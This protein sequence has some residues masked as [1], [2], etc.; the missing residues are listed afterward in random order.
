MNSAIRI[1]S[2][3]K[4]LRTI[5]DRGLIPGLHSHT[6]SRTT[7][8]C[9]AEHWP[10][11]HLLISSYEIIMLDSKLPGDTVYFCNMGLLYTGLS[12]LHQMRKDL[13]VCYLWRHKDLDFLNFFYI[14]A[15]FGPNLEKVSFL[16]EIRCC[17][18]DLQAFNG[19]MV[20]LKISHFFT[21]LSH[22]SHIWMMPYSVLP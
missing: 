2:L 1:F 19:L 13:V 11:I 8:F 12:G 21:F 10:A 9:Y 3:F 22:L 16:V 15:I 7:T 20:L 5:S 4:R 17:K 6:E 18:L 14:F